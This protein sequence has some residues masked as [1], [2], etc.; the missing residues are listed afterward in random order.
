[1]EVARELAGG[2]SLRV[3]V[4]LSTTG[5]AVAE[6]VGE[7]LGAAGVGVVDAPVSGGS[8]GAESGQLT[9]MVSGAP[10]PVAIARPV[11]EPLGS[12]I[13]VV[14]DRP[15][16]G[17]A[18]KVI[19]NL[20]SACS[21]AIT[22]EA[23]SL[24]VK[25]GLDPATL[26]EVIAAS[27]GSN[28]AAAQKFPAYVLTRTF[29]QGFRLRLM[30]KDVRLCLSEARRHQVPMLLGATVEQLWN[31]G[32]ATFPDDADF[33]E[34]VKMFEEWANVRIEGAANAGRSPS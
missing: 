31:L 14:G 22:A 18:V 32:D 34:I 8:A 4:D 27:S 15:G 2:S 6:E 16:Q 25:A 19:N 29:H 10:E 24:G 9:I 28:T 3:Y 7:L 5:P 1:S 23:T 20:M 30:A 11:L 33:I 13:F 21:L 26:L 12:R 17:Q